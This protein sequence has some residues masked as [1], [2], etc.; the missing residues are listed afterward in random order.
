MYACK[1]L[2]VSAPYLRISRAKQNREINR[3]RI[4]TA[5]H[6]T[7]QNYCSISNY[8]VVI[9]QNKGAKIILHVKSPTFRS[10]KLKGFTVCF[11][12]LKPN[13]SKYLLGRCTFMCVFYSTMLCHF[14]VCISL[15][16]T[17]KLHLHVCSYYGL[18]LSNL[19]KETTYLLTYLLI[20][21]CHT[22]S[23]LIHSLCTES[24]IERRRKI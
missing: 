3:A 20:T 15:Y 16:Q 14:I 1:T 7:G 23:F 4:S 8:M 10:A 21:L 17:V 9:R 19:I 2:N 24:T 18:R 12:P 11:Y 22:V 6:K 13:S 5:G